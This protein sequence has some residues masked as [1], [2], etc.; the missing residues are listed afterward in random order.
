MKL[1][2]YGNDTLVVCP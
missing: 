1:A 2:F